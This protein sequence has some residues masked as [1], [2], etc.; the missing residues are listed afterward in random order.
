MKKV[1]CTVDFGSSVDKIW[2]IITDN[3][4]YTWRSDL[5][6]IEVSDGGNHFVEY[7]KNGYATEFTV[8]L[9]IPHERYEFDMKND[10]MAGHWT[11]VFHQ[12]NG[13]TKVTFIEEVEAKGLVKQLFAGVYLKK[14]QKAYIAD[15]KR[16]LGE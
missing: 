2:Q 16:A 15:L 12:V 4:N 11:G 14:Q 13:R 1:E 3:S 9:K 7:T 8:T 10:N 5:A 6:K